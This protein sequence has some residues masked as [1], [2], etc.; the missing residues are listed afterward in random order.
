MAGTV[1][2]F[3]LDMKTRGCQHQTT[4]HHAICLAIQGWVACCACALRIM[5]RL[6]VTFKHNVPFLRP[7][8]LLD[9]IPSICC[10]N[11]NAPERPPRKQV[12]VQIQPF[13]FGLTATFKPSKSAKPHVH[14]THRT[15]EGKTPAITVKPMAIPSG[16]TAL[17]IRVPTWASL[18]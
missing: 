4:A 15:P 17:R 14:P 18:F 8:P 11:S 5:Q 13:Q 6:D 12:P 2:L 7:T 1:A 9:Q 3:S 16:S 10:E